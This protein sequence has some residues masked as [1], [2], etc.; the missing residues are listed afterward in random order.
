[1]LNICFSDLNIYGNG[2]DWE[3]FCF[4]DIDGDCKMDVFFFWKG[5]FVY[6][7]GGKGDVIIFCKVDVLIEYVFIGDFDGD[8]K[9]E[10]FYKFR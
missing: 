7:F 5:N 9:V 1:M 4:G 3:D 10:I 6:V 8:K 2:V